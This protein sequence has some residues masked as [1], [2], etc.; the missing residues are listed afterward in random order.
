MNLLQR[1]LS[2]LFI[3]IL[4]VIVGLVVTNSKLALLIS[5]FIALLSFWKKENGILFLLI[6]I[7]LRPF[8]IAVNPGYKVIGD[9]IIGLLLIRT[10]W[11]S[12]KELR[13]LFTFH[14]F[15]LAFF[16][17]AVIGVLSALITDVSLKAIIVQLRA[18]FLFYL[19]YYI[20]KRMDF[21]SEMIRRMS[22][23]TFFLAVIMS[24]QGIVEKISNKTA[25]MPQEWQEW[26]LSPTNRIRVYGLLKGPNEL[27]LY[28][29]IAF[30]ISLYLLKQVRGKA[31]SFLYVGMT[32]MGTTILL[33]YSRGTLL[34]LFAFLFIYVIVNRKWRPFVKLSIV[35]I[36]SIGLFFGVNQAADLYYNHYL[37]GEDQ[38]GYGNDNDSGSKRYKNAFSEETIGQSSSSG[39]LYYVKKAVE[40]FKDHPIIGT[41]FG[42]FGGAATLAYSSPIYDDYGIETNFYSDNQYIL[43]LAETGI[44]GTLALILV[45]YF[46]LVVT[47]K[48]RK[49]FYGPLLSY[50]FI[51]LIVGGAVYNILENDTFMMFYFILLGIVLNKQINKE[52]DSFI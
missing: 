33:T 19:V 9:A 21:T 39:R 12:R 4:A 3:G 46:L 32:L 27:S 2:I 51:A 15:E 6:F 13:K 18:Y 48:N 20:V 8:L 40:I 22:Y 42:T 28:L 7:P 29:L 14:H 36:V 11:D 31:R 34:T 30:I 45:S 47:W 52:P 25:L 1:N 35:A 23:T 50:L 17:F 37:T 44:L 49:K 38:E 5:V 16:A 26:W 24:I 43:V 41:G 10:I